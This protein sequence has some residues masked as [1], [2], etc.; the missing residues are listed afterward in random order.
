MRFQVLVFGAQGLRLAPSCSP[1]TPTVCSIPGLLES[2]PHVGKES[3]RYPDQSPV[4]KGRSSCTET[5]GWLHSTPWCSHTYASADKPHGN[6]RV[7]P[8]PLPGLVN[9]TPTGAVSQGG[10]ALT[11]RAP[12]RPYLPHAHTY[13]G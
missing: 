7:W 8:V 13:K 12:P 2:S 9:G 4:V 1:G 3:I 5:L 11:I 6:G 10:G